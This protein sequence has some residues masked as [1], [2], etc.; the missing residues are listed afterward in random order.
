MIELWGVQK[1][2]AHTGL[3][4]ARPMLEDGLTGNERYTLDDI[5]DDVRS[6]NMQ[7]W[8]AWTGDAVVKAVGVTEIFGH[9]PAKTCC[10]VYATGDLEVLMNHIKTLEDWA[11]SLDCKVEIFGRPGWVKMLPDYEIKHVLLERTT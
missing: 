6:G 9:G 3:A 10:I 11:K 8:I 2:Q 4:L 1:H 5:E 7:L